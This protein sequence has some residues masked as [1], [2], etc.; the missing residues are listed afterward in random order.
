[1]FEYFIVSD[2]E[3]KKTNYQNP[4]FSGT[5]YT[6][7][8][9][10]EQTI[11]EMIDLNGLNYIN[12]KTM[13][14]TVEKDNMKTLLHKFLANA[15]VYPVVN[16]FV[17]KRIDDKL[18]GDNS[19][20]SHETYFKDVLKLQKDKSVK[21]TDNDLSCANLHETVKNELLKLSENPK[22]FVHKKDYT[23]KVYEFREVEK[24][25]FAIDIEDDMSVAIIDYSIR[26]S[27]SRKKGKK[28]KKKPTVESLDLPR[29]KFLKLQ[30]EKNTQKIAITG[31]VVINAKEVDYYTVIDEMVGEG[32]QHKKNKCK[33]SGVQTITINK[34][35]NKENEVR[36]KNFLKENTYYKLS[37]ISIEEAI[38]RILPLET[39]STSLAAL[40]TTSFDMNDYVDKNECSNSAIFDF[41]KKDIQPSK[42]KTTGIVQDF[43]TAGKVYRIDDRKPKNTNKVVPKLPKDFFNTNREFK[44]DIISNLKDKFEEW[45]NEIIQ[46]L[47]SN[48]DAAS[49][50]LSINKDMIKVVTNYFNKTHEIKY[51][52]ELKKEIKDN[53]PIL[54]E[55][56]S[57]DD[58]SRIF[59]NVNRKDQIK[60]TIAQFE[61][62]KNDEKIFSSLN[63]ILTQGLANITIEMIPILI[64]SVGFPTLE[65]S[66]ARSMYSLFIQSNDPNDKK[67]KRIYSRGEN[68]K[69]APPVD[70]ILALAALYIIYSQ[71]ENKSF[72]VKPGFEKFYE[73]QSWPLWEKNTKFEDPSPILYVAHVF[74][75]R[76]VALAPY[77][78]EKYEISMSAIKTVKKAYDT[79]VLYVKIHLAINDKIKNFLADKRKELEK[80]IVIDN[81]DDNAS[82]VNDLELYEKNSMGERPKQVT[83]E[84]MFSTRTKG[85]SVTNNSQL[86]PQKYEVTSDGRSEGNSEFKDTLKKV[87]DEN[88]LKH[89]INNFN[90][91]F[92]A[93][94]EKLRKREE[95]ISQKISDIKNEADDIYSSRFVQKSFHDKELVKKLGKLGKLGYKFV[96]EIYFKSETLFAS[97]ISITEKM[98]VKLFCVVLK[99][100]NL[101]IAK[102]DK[103]AEE[104]K[105]LYVEHLKEVFK[106]LGSE[107]VVR[108]ERGSSE[109]ENILAQD[110]DEE[111]SEEEDS[112]EEFNDDEDDDN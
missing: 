41:G 22:E 61:S 55:Y 111:D 79:I 44:G 65:L 110:I 48:Q 86:G 70:R 19:T 45:E 89:K 60:K 66:N 103:E 47:E 95:E 36:S 73:H 54:N 96:R 64:E 68:L 102:E 4:F 6:T 99:L 97:S 109:V 74:V 24:E 84:K 77:E 49:N 71:L 39:I 90:A 108:D 11:T 58:P 57:R 5:K 12:L 107:N 72:H 34:D 56:Y 35:Y 31:F 27:E 75:E 81:G 59:Q 23:Q 91:D 92:G 98:K 88:D 100:L 30:P 2:P 52:S 26:S 28:K 14:S 101:F 17:K 46:E 25:D 37:D 1:M 13:I 53:T 51:R 42:R 43:E 63:R 78:F 16:K 83:I 18:D 76:L 50:T 93:Q 67:Y 10:E 62:F 8:F 94:I 20:I 38:E 7:Q 105:R 9:S 15:N 104:N 106:N 33:S 40:N 112:D 32:D 85:V 3:L 80:T 82:A 21:L 87:L 69:K 29:L